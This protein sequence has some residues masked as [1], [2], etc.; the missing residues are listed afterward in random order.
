[1]RKL[2]I[3]FSLFVMVFFILATTLCVQTLS[4]VKAVSNFDEG[5][6]RIVLDAGHGGIDGGVVGKTTRV[7]ESDVNLQITLALQSALEEKG[8][9]VTLTRKTE[10]GLYGAPTK[11]FKRRDM[12]RRKEIIEETK[13]VL[14][15]SIHQNLYSS[16]SSRGGQVFYNKNSAKGK[17]LSE[18]LQRQL[19]GLY[20]EQ[21]VKSRNMMAGQYYML[22]CTPYPTA[23]VEC[24][25]LSNEK[26]EKLLTSPEWQEK[27]A[28]VLT[29][30]VME[31]LFDA[32]A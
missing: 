8:F 30:G 10:A 13:P 6:M 18:I 11:G 12:E 7:K 9:E 20:K 2:S 21:G 27:L 28:E 29:I 26:D 32:M 25:F 17:Q 3:L 22:E 14:V 24:G 23:L 4:G 31:Y 16:S 19:N 5:G 1:M 15:I